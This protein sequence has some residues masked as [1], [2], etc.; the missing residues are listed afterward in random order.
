MDEH[1]FLDFKAGGARTPLM[2][3]VAIYANRFGRGHSQP[4]LIALDFHY[5]DGYAARNYDLFTNTS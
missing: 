1:R 3:L 5:G 2:N 4:H